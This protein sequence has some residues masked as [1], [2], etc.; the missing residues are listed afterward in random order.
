MTVEQAESLEDSVAAW[1]TLFTLGTSDVFAMTSWS[2][3][4][5]TL[6]RMCSE[7]GPLFVPSALPHSE[8]VH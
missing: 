4:C 6:E 8:G 7:G 3:C 5:T 1:G 2:E